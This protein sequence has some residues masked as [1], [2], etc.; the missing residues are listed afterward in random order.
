MKSHACFSV[1]ATPTQT[2]QPSEEWPLNVGADQST[3]CSYF[4]TH[5][6]THTLQSPTTK[7]K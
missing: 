2:P 3:S 7:N 1:N 6:H 5:T 4:V